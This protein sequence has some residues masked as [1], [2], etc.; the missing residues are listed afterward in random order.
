MHQQCAPKGTFP[1]LPPTLPP[2]H[3]PCPAACPSLCRPCTRPRLCHRLG[4][5]WV[6]T[7]S[8]HRAYCKR[9]PRA[10]AVQHSGEGCRDGGSALGTGMHCNQ[11]CLAARTRHATCAIRSAAAAGTRH[12]TLP[13]AVKQ[14]QPS[15]CT[16]CT[17]A[18]CSRL[19]S[20]C[21]SSPDPRIAT[22][23]PAGPTD[24]VR[25]ASALPPMKDEPPARRA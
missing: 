10:A 11:H 4:D 12:V 20:F 13:C 25:R 17:C 18:S 8:I 16:C 21:L 6:C 15:C 1:T 24:S 7:G 5:R 23:S 9:H 2:F 22:P 14:C 19:A 3:P